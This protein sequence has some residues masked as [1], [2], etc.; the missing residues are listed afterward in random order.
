MSARESLD[1]DEQRN[2]PGQESIR[3]REKKNGSSSF[4]FAEGNAHT[5]R[6]L[7]RP[8]TKLIAIRVGNAMKL[9]MGVTT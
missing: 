9:E 2:S 1:G 5:G 6:L 4:F 7:V 8:E 3:E